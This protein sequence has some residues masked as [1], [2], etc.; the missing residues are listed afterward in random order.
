MEGEERP[1]PPA[2]NKTKEDWPDS[3]DKTITVSTTWRFYEMY[4]WNE[5]RIHR[6]EALIARF[7][8][9]S[10]RF[11]R[12]SCCGDIFVGWIPDG[13]VQQF[14]KTFP[15]ENLQHEDALVREFQLLLESENL[16]N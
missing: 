12:R 16:E 11:L 6:L 15:G 8:M 1:D 4:K 9:M 7:A 14:E 5:V 2:E 13:D 3:Y 10:V